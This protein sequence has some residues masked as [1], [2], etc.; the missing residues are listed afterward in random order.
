MQTYLR[1]VSTHITVV[2]RMLLMCL[3]LDDRKNQHRR[4]LR[5][6]GLLADFSASPISDS[7]LNTG[8]ILLSIAAEAL[9]PEC[10]I[11]SRWDDERPL[12]VETATSPR[13]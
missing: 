12:N 11:A 4:M 5:E 2:D 1:L 6:F 10:F 3:A 13:S 9:D 7:E 8:N